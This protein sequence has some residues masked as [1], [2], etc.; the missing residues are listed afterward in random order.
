MYSPEPMLDRVLRPSPPM[1]PRA[2]LIILMIV[3]AM[4]L[5]FAGYFVLHGAWPVTPFMGADVALLAWAFQASLK[6]AK[7]EEQI[8]L[9]PQELRVVR[10]APGKQTGEYH[11]NPYWVSVDLD[12]SPDHARIFHGEVPQASRLTLWSHGK[13]LTIGSF[14]SPMVRAEFGAELKAALRRAKGFG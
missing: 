4:N 2:L 3:G 11:L 7:R 9:T 1:P 14:L 13:G 6:A 8:I 10:R 5:L 12:E